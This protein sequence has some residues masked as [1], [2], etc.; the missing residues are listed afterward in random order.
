MAAL[1]APSL[2]WGHG[3]GFCFVALAT[4]CLPQ[5]T[6]AEPSRDV[7]N[8]LGKLVSQIR[9]FPISD[10]VQLS[11]AD[12]QP[13]NTKRRRGELQ[14]PEDSGWLVAD[15][16]NGT[17][18]T[19]FTIRWLRSSEQTLPAT[20]GV[21]FSLPPYPEQPAPAPASTFTRSCVDG[22]A[23]SDE[24]NITRV[25]RR[26]CVNVISENVPVTRDVLA[27]LAEQA[28]NDPANV[29]TIKLAFT[30]DTK[31]PA[32]D[33]LRFFPAE[34]RALLAAVDNQL[35]SKSRLDRLAPKQ[36]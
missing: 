7:S 5:S 25:Y 23:Q 27:Y 32:G 4:M 1:F 24:F 20:S 30:D 22:H 16:L 14:R 26:T 6:K 11:T 31:Y 33:Q 12:V 18:P 35:A 29:M 2:G 21:R 36:N 8:P 3:A 19:I 10:G 13:L 28:D 9:S 34:A 17:G 15:V